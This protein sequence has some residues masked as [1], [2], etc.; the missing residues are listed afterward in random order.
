MSSVY[1]IGQEYI[2]EE[3]ESIL[4]RYAPCYNPFTGFMTFIMIFTN[5]GF[6]VYLASRARITLNVESSV[7]CVGG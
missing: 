6:T 4:L 5:V 1:S 3:G 2:I 7:G